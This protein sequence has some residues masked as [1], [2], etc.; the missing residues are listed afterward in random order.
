MLLASVFL[1]VLSIISC[2][3]FSK[4]LP[5]QHLLSPVFRC[6]IDDYTDLYVQFSLFNIRNCVYVVRSIYLCKRL[7]GIE[8]YLFPITFIT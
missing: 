2:R 7:F 8:F 4:A 1:T 3:I 6:F 5:K